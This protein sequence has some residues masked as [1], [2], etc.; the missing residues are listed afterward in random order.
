MATTLEKLRAFQV[1]HT[2]P[3]IHKACEVLIST[4][5]EDEYRND[6]ANPWSNE[7]LETMRMLMSVR[8]RN[9]SLD[10]EAAMREVKALLKITDRTINTF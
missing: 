10:Y 5:T 2:A 7:E 6:L 9:R 4:I 1:S 8:T 3:E